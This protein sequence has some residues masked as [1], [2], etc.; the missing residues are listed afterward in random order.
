MSVN[1]KTLTELSPEQSRRMNTGSSVSNYDRPELS[2]SLSATKRNADLLTSRGVV[3]RSET[4]TE[5]LA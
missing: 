4:L 5:S 2:V 1:R 3:T